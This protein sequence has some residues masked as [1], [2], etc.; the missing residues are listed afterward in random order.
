LIP[1]QNF[2]PSKCLIYERHWRIEL[3]TLW[4]VIFV[5]TLK[6]S[7]LYS[8]EDFKVPINHFFFILHIQHTNIS[9]MKFVC[10]CLF[11][12]FCF[13]FNN[14]RAN[15]YTVEY[16]E[17]TNCTSS[18]ATLVLPQLVRSQCAT[19]IDP[20]QG[21]TDAY[22]S[23]GTCV[24]GKFGLDNPGNQY[25]LFENATDCP[26]YQPIPSIFL[27]SAITT[28]RYAYGNCLPGMITLGLNAP[29]YVSA[30]LLS[31]P[32][33]ITT[34]EDPDEIEEPPIDQVD[35]KDNEAIT[36]PSVI[37]EII[38][39]FALRQQSSSSPVPIPV[40]LEISIQID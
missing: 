19:T 1:K 22:M 32:P 33:P 17:D 18:L 24:Q 7:K 35:Q 13:Y 21:Y 12:F 20:T 30:R 27:F 36:P 15:T 23:W 31:C 6:I 5:S 9:I 38:K 40:E 4:I 29:I 34:S 25:F 3:K 37:S 16:F 26:I 39:A 14:V 2:H 28:T 8:I 11:Y 10:I